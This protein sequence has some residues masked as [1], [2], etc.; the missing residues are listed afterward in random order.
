MQ[1]RFRPINYPT[2]AAA[3]TTLG[4][5]SDVDLTGAATND[6]LY[7]NGTSWVDSAGALQ[8][9]GTDSLILSDATQEMTFDVGGIVA[10][11][12]GIWLHQ[13][14][15]SSTNYALLGDSSN[16]TLVNAAG[17]LYLRQG[18]SNK[19]LVT[20]T[21][22]QVA[23][24]LI[25]ATGNNF[26]VYDSGG[27]DYAQ[28]SHDGTDFNTSFTNTTDWNVTGWTGLLKFEGDVSVRSGNSFY[29]Q[30]ATNGDNVGFTHDGTDLNT[31]FANTTDWNVTGLTNFN[32]LQGMQFRI[33]GPTNAG[34]IV[35]AHNDTDLNITNVNTTDWNVIGLT[36][37]VWIRD[38]AF[39]KISD[40]TD[41]DYATFS[42]DGTDF[43]TVF[44]NT[45]DWNIDISVLKVEAGGAYGLWYN[46]SNGALQLRQASSL[47]IFDAT[48][49]DKA[50]FSHDGTDFNTVYTNTARVTQS[51]ASSMDFEGGMDIRVLDGGNIQVFD[52]TDT[53]W[54]RLR[55]DGSA[56]R[57]EHSGTT[58]WYIEG[59]TTGVVFDNGM[60]T[61]HRDASQTN[62]MQMYH[63]GTD[64]YFNS[65]ATVGDVH[66]ETGITGDIILQGQ[67]IE[68]SFGNK[69]ADAVQQT[70]WPRG[71][72]F[73]VD[74]ASQSGA[75]RIELD[76]G[77]N[78]TMV[79]LRLSGYTY[80]TGSGNPGGPWEVLVGG[81][82]YA[83]TPTWIN[84]GAHLIAG[85][86]PFD[87]VKFQV[88][89][90]NE[91]FIQLGETT[92][93]WQY[94]QLNVE[95]LSEGFGGQAATT[96]S[97][98]ITQETTETA[99][100]SNVYEFN[101]WCANEN[102]SGNAYQRRRLPANGTGTMWLDG[103][104]H[105]FYDSANTDY[106]QVYHS[107]T[108]ATFNESTNS[109]FDFQLGGGLEG[110][111]RADWWFFSTPL[112]LLER[113]SAQTDSGGYGQ[114]WI[115]S[116]TPNTF[117]FTDDAG[118]DHTIAALDQAGTFSAIQTFS[119]SPVI[120]SGSLFIDEGSAAEG[121]QAGKGQFWVQ[122]DAP[123]RP[124]F[125]DDAGNDYPLG[126]AKWLNVSEDASDTC[127][128]QYMNGVYFKDGTGAITL[129]LEASSVTTFEVG[130]TTAIINAH[131]TTGD[132]TVTE[133]TGTTLYVMDG[134]SVTD[135][136]GNATIGPGGYATL[137]R[138]STTVYYLM[139]SG[140][141]A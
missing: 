67:A 8:W 39:L 16:N 37:G 129:T 26:F 21:S 65:N 99:V 89:T 92:D 32:L 113:A 103:W 44:T 115:K 15:E 107:G 55:H 34:Q 18:N 54:V 3:A 19:V 33:A 120:S 110:G 38:G 97:I 35:Y 61:F 114:I 76:G 1:R 52:S 25:V 136:A 95:V 13:T 4:D 100:S 124:Y 104:Q 72:E 91:C 112:K 69:D 74:S 85:Y 71:G 64:F 73:S 36:G 29:I 130:S 56:G 66:F 60:S 70:L 109:G 45:T 42:H 46:T 135:S 12:H 128:W 53:D 96:P 77:F 2:V 106:L 101:V 68:H 28:F 140:I 88:G 14:A 125:T 105:F 48:Q 98:T 27:T 102:V 58:H 23:D 81:Y 24:D 5:L 84:C 93:T 90:A 94:P 11:H 117:M 127:D 108:Y 41:T 31:V 6:M 22:V 131:A 10:N 83:A 9:D 122:D 134:S 87:Y 78:N 17:T 138:H 132:I 40:S 50:V 49:T 133:G 7:Y 62:Y 137:Y 116:D 82:A 57:W 59:L 111:I 123:N 118:N 63:D 139:G 43:N 119:A 86:P 20:S 51:G 47:Q 79:W 141:T 80:A 75:I 121:D 30:D 126:F